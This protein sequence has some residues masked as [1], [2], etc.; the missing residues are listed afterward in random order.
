M[1]LLNRSP[2]TLRVLQIAADHLGIGIR[3]TI[4]LSLSLVYL[5]GLLI[6]AT[7]GEASAYLGFLTGAVMLAGIGLVV[8]CAEEARLRYRKY[9]AEWPAAFG[10]DVHDHL[11]THW[12]NLCNDLRAL[13]PVV[14][15]ALLG[16]I[17][18]AWIR[19]AGGTGF[20]VSQPVR[21]VILGPLPLFVFVMILGAGVGGAAGFALHFA[22]EHVRFIR[23]VSSLP[24]DPF[25]FLAGETSL[26]GLS[27]LVT[28]FVTLWF[29]GVGLTTFVL[30]Q[31]VDW[32]SIGVYLA[33]VA[34]GLAIFCSSQ[35]YFHKIL[36]ASKRHAKQ[37]LWD[38]LRTTGSPRDLAA[39]DHQSMG[40]LALI[41]ESENL[42]EW[43]VD[44]GHVMALVVGVVGPY[45]LSF[46]PVPI[47]GRG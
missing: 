38:R 8:G 45:V 35:W 27:T 18:V 30:L 10:P 22:W 47:P 3:S 12:V 34:G 5:V 23:R 33:G 46:A 15:L 11:R 25:R 26:D 39:I 37:I 42:K 19:A 40:T 17:Y 43:T 2:K 21:L 31:T 4:F 1:H 29:V 16:A 32:F 24:I 13:A 14:P 20:D 44:L 28:G 41:R 9:M 6:A 7:E 36:V